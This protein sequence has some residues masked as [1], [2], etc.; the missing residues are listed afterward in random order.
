MRYW[1]RGGAENVQR[2]QENR[3]DVLANFRV[4]GKILL[5]YWTVV[6]ITGFAGLF[7]MLLATTQISP[8]YAST[9]TL[10][11]SV[12]ASNTGATGDLVQG[13]NFAQSAMPN[14]LDLVTTAMVLNRVAE[15]IDHALTRQELG[16]VLSVTS[17]PNSVLLDITVTHE[18]AALAINVANTTGK[19]FTQVVENEL[20]AGSADDRS[21]V[22]VR[23]VDLAS[24]SQQLG[25]PDYLRNGSVGMFLGLLL[26]AGIAVLR[27]LF[28]TRVHTAEDLERVTNIPVLGRIPNDEHI[29]QRPLILHDGAANGRAE[30]FRML[31]TNLQFLGR[32]ESCQT[33]L[34]TSAMPGTGKTHIISNLAIVLAETGARV[35]LIDCDLRNPRLAHVMGIE[36][37]A[38][39]SD[40][41]IDRA[42]L[43]DV[44]QPWGLHNLRVLPSGQIPPNPSELLGSQGMRDLL[45]EIEQTSDY[46]LLD[47]PPVLPVTDAAV[48]ASLVSGTLLVVA[49]EQTKWREAV[50][51]LEALESVESNLLG[52]VTNRET[53]VATTTRHNVYGYGERRVRS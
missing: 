16:R 4:L 34:A 45:R 24:E 32:G 20:Q 12:R 35:T 15:D 27:H 5:K 47:T 50:Q 38:G 9:T 8:K 36:G 28:D 41:L 52:F 7:L 31:R 26:G 22:Q 30:A 2:K 37:S 33:Y 39:L 49:I 23:T 19:V 21:A 40:V 51:A 17:P 6:A 13:T 48:A 46:V 10:Y 29:A 42:K 43:E 14:Y 53:S 18:D 44:L 1:S 25:G 11:I 3:R